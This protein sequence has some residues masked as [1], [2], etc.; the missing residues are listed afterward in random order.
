MKRHFPLLLALFLCVTL[1]FTA[2]TKPDTDTQENETQDTANTSVPTEN[3]TQNVTAVPTAE[4][5]PIPCTLTFDTNRDSNW[6]IYSM[7]SD[8]SNQ[9]NLSNNSADDFD[10]V[11]S[12][13]GSQI[14][15]VSNRENEVPGQYIYVMNADGSDVF[16]LTFENGSDF[17][18]WSHDSSA[19]TYTSN[20][21]IYVIKADGSGQSINLTN[22]PEI[23]HRSSWSPNG[24]MLVFT[25]GEDQ[26][27]N[28]YVMDPDGNNITQVTD[29]GQNYLAQWTID[30]R[31]FT[32]WG[33]KDQEQVCNNCVVNPDG[34]NIMEAGGKGML[35]RY[36]PFWTGD[37]ERVECANIAF[38][39]APTA[40]IYLIGEIYTDGMLNLTNTEA[41]ERNVDWPANCGQDP[42]V[43]GYT[44]DESSDQSRHNS[45][46][47]AC[48]ELALLCPSGT[49]TDLV[50]QGV[51]AIVLNSLN[52][53]PLEDPATIE[54]A[55]DAGIPV[56]LLDA[57]LDLPG[58]YSVTVDQTKWVQTGLEWMFEKMGGEGKFAYF[59]LYPSLG[60]LEAIKE[61]L[62]R[63]PE[64]SVIDHRDAADDPWASKP[65]TAE[66]L[67]T[68]PE[69]EAIWTNGF[70]DGIIQGVVEESG[71]APDKWPLMMCEASWSGMSYWGD[72]LKQ[73]S[74]FECIA[75]GN[76]SGI[77][78][79][80][81]YTAY[82]LLSGE[83]IDPSVLG[84]KYG[85]SLLVDFPVV[86]NENRQEMLETNPGLDQY[87]SPE[88]ILEQW[89]LD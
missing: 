18:D 86:T 38:N 78:Y 8:G 85:N 60:H 25:I 11:W 49:M 28:I 19:I 75:V 72:K 61:M 41:D 82:Y 57:E 1:I 17:P 3:P 77:A 73:N 63:Y 67:Q 64:I 31:I 71:A 36:F 32:G 44:D 23:E 84:G 66:L 83:E 46:Q 89:F 26:N 88:E 43:I 47:S 58:V 2:C 15:F 12:P 59:D 74:N 79:D 53:T 29:N 10:P 34:S 6:E 24:R 39:A 80:A 87:M 14:A 13:D 45:F 65:I 55:V 81:F 48:D 37:G 4:P 21:D 16:Q 62:S 54:A 42:M 35:K 33:W 7:T 56:F 76:P 68:N 22:S 70:Y 52:G 9:V 51:D 69:I 40:D 27:Q 20:G 50:E 30:N 5:E